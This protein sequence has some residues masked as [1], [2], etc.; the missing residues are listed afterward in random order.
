MT[1]ELWEQVKR[2]FGD[3]LDYEPSEREA[4][5]REAAGQNS[6]LLVELLRMLKENERD[7]DL[8]SQFAIADPR[9]LRPDDRPRFS[10]DAV[11]ARRFRIIRFITRGGMG[12]VYEAEDLDLAERVALKAI[13]P[14]LAADSEIRALFKREIQLARRVT[15]PNVCRI[16]DLHED[17]VQGEPVLL[18]SME[19]IEGKTLAQHLREHGPLSFRQAL[20]LVGQIAAGLQAVHDAG[21]IH[22]DLKPGNVMLSRSQAKVMDFGVALPISEAGPGAFS[23]TGL[24]PANTG[25][26]VLRGGTPEYL[27]PE[28]HE[29]APASTATD[30]Y[31]L[32]LV[33]GDILGIP[34]EALIGAKTKLPGRWAHVL[35]RCL[36]SEPAKR[37]SRPADVAAALHTRTPRLPPFTIATLLAA[38]LATIALVAA[39]RIDLGR[40][41]SN[42]LV[43]SEG[44]KTVQ[45]VSP[46]GRFLAMTSWNT[47]DL[48]LYE[49]ANEKT[50]TLTH[51]GTT[52][53]QDFG[54]VYGAEFSPD[55]RSIAYIWAN[56]R[57][58]SEIRI[59]GSDGKGERTL[60]HNAAATLNLIDWSDDGTRILAELAQDDGAP[61]ELVSLS[62][63]T[64]GLERLKNPRGEHVLWA[65]DGQSVVVDAGMEIHRLAPNGTEQVLVGHIG[66]NSAIGWSPDRR[67]LIFLSDRRGHPGIWS[68][69]VS[70]QGPQGEPS[71]LVPDARNWEPIGLTRSGALFYR[72]NSDLVDI[73]TA[74][75]D[76][77]GHRLDSPPQR[78]TERFI[79]TYAYP[80]WSDDGRQLV[81]DSNR[82]API[83]GLAI[84]ETQT[85][86]IREMQLDIT[87]AYRPQWHGNTII[88]P[89]RG[90]DGS[91]GLFQVD[92][93]TGAS[94][95]FRKSELIGSHFEGIWSRDGKIHF[96]RFDDSRRG[97]FRLNV[98]TG[99][100]RALYVPPK[101]VD[102]GTENLALSPDQGTLAFQARGKAE[103][104]LMLIS[105]D[106][107][108][109][110]PLFTI[111][112]PQG[113]PY[114]SFTWTPD[115]H[116]VLAVVNHPGRT[117]N[118]EAISEV[119]QIPVD[120][121]PAVK[122]DFPEQWITSLRLNPD[123][124]TLAFQ[125]RHRR[126]E[127]WVLQNFL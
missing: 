23:S 66:S 69:P 88:L 105:P 53:S 117:P 24:S 22:G 40:T 99:E 72:H 54:G 81:F 11:L 18:L 48:A 60:Y 101:G 62:P 87:Q 123:G 107:G 125:V 46:D 17:S 3:A 86:R 42:L 109:A 30:I 37:Y 55:G 1:P 114:G 90:P 74:V 38:V 21:V 91:R 15:H 39:K 58:D 111:K 63:R 61:R 97:I 103:A 121:S 127:I 51:K 116:S 44:N 52:W 8:L 64:G 49:V 119:W 45:A 77:A 7:T 16:F 102:V 110:R 13:R 4:F 89:A 14:R 106:G 100:R 36:E 50:K 96:N 26:G 2:I 56:S 113:F 98:E 20:P 71:E 33:I 31:A 92:P 115:S 35:R 122:I 67:R 34:R 83:A 12:E 41:T 5:V 59:V 43:L 126:N 10:A 68:I 75:V 25:S 82:N 104:A 57:T 28:Q 70:D 78:L 27:A 108:N 118:S 47:G 6:D 124:K 80:N 32:A 79:G 95:L 76:L 94:S 93:Q 9:A 73:Y 112:A 29:R 85:G 84:Y 65:P 19:L 120:G